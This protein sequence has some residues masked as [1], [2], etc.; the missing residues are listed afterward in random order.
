MNSIIL[1]LVTSVCKKPAKSVVLV[2]DLV[3]NWSIAQPEVKLPKIAPIPLVIII[4]K[5]C[6]EERFFESVFVST[7]NDPEILKKSKAIP[8]TTHDK[9]IIHNPFTGSP[10]AK[11][12][13]RNTQANILI[14]I[15]CLIPKRFKK[16]GIAKINKVSDI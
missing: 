12:P 5:P 15:T 4:N 7:N 2:N 10:K 14:N 6:A 8:Y 16:N 9:I 11:S 13:K 3:K 1:G